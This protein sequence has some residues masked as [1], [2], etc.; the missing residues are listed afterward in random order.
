[1]PEPGPVR[2]PNALGKDGAVVKAGIVIKD[3]NWIESQLKAIAKTLTLLSVRLEQVETLLVAK[4]DP[5]AK[6]RTR[7]AMA[8]LVEIDRQF[9]EK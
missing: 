8:R 7:A 4:P 1:M 2:M 3:K 5:R 6:A 9:S